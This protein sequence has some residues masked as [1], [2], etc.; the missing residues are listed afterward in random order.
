MYRIYKNNVTTLGLYSVPLFAALDRIW[1]LMAD[2]LNMSNKNI[3]SRDNSVCIVTGYGAEWPKGRSSSPGSQD[4]S[5]ST[6]SGPVLGP[7]QPLIQWVKWSGLEADHSPT[8][9]GV[10]TWIYMSI[11]PYAFMVC[12]A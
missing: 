2:V 3:R 8:T 9:T 10:N 5:L 4:F 11:P 7:T 1:T 12:G 6:S